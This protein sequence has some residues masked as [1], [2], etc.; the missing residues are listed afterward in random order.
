MKENIQD[1]MRAK[2]LIAEKG[3]KH[4]MDESLE[5]KD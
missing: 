1:G 4:K 3:E 5:R 2:E